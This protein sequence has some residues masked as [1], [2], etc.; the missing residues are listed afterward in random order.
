MSAK[1]LHVG[2]RLLESLQ[3]FARPNLEGVT[4]VLHL[5]A[6]DALQA[7]H[8]SAWHSSAGATVTVLSYCSATVPPNRVK[9]ATKAGANDE[10]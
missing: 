2:K 9:K 5:S 10:T 7:L 3:Q 4:C 8:G 6:V 1:I